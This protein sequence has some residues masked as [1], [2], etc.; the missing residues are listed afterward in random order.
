MECFNRHFIRI[1]ESG[2]VECGFSDAF[3]QAQPD[4]ICINKQGGY[5][6]RLFAEGMENP[7][8]TDD[9]GNPLYRWNGT[10]VMEA[11]K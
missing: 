5:Q 6:F 2:Y 10:R 4:D 3:E 8:L 1:N 11:A 7:R 9:E